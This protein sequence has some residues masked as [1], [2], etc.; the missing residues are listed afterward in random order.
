MEALQSFF[1]FIFGYI[2]FL[3]VVVVPTYSAAVYANCVTGDS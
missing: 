1:A 3:M 2:G